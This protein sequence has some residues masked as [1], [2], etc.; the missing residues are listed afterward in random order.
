MSERAPALASE[1][2]RTDVITVRAEDTV[3]EAARTLR[4]EGHS[5]A[6]VLDSGDRLAG[7]ITERDIVAVVVDGVDPA[8]CKVGARMS[9]GVVTVTTATPAARARELMSKHTI[10]HLPVLEGQRVIGIV[11]A[12]SA[13]ARA[14]AEAPRAELGSTGV[15]TAFRGPWADGPPPGAL[16]VDAPPLDKPAVGDLFRLVAV[17]W[18]IAWSVLR[19]VAKWVFRRHGRSLALAA[20]HGLVDAFEKLGPTFVKAGQLVTS[21]PGV[22][23]EPLAEACKRCLDNV[24][25]FPAEAVR[26]VVEEDLGRPVA[27][28][29]RSFD[30]QPLASASIAQVHACVLPDGREAVV[31][32]QRPGIRKTINADLRILY[33]LAQLAEK[34]KL[35]ER[36]QPC[37]FIADMHKVSNQEVVC[38]LEADRQ[39]RFRNAI[40]AFGDNA[41]VTAPEVYWDYCGPRVICMER[42]YGVPIDSFEILKERKIDSQ[43]LLRKGIKVGMESICVHGPFHGD[44]HAGNIWVLDD[45]RAAYLDFG[46]MGE[47]PDPWKKL[48]IDL[49][50]TTL[51]DNN[52]AR[53]VRN[54]KDV[55]V[56]SEDVGPDDEVGARLPM[57]M[58]PLMELDASSVDLGEVF[59]QQIALAESMGAKAPQ[60]L[61][62]VSKQVFYFERYVK[63]LAPGYAMAKDLYLFRNIMPEV[64]AA[65]AAELGVTFPD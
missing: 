54:Y 53:V 27:Q 7:I 25:P 50:R 51:I 16:K 12:D 46:L 8:G 64:I 30:D 65:K 52:W 31:K 60:E 29:F 17:G 36:L 2:M 37:A 45:G 34:T 26:R 18:L 49:F 55:G 1:I 61:M 21:S 23:P 20:S 35:G 5:A 63:G 6:V 4:K 43:T 57:V 28:L 13:L 62:L 42:M 59:K 44:V 40:G 48:I 9:T 32:V 22:F 3:A 19:S 39:T 10:R 56:L 15:L 58:P 41:D 24:P 14:A 38:A 47:L 33:R 11:T